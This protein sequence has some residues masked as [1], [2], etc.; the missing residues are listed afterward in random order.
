MKEIDWKHDQISQLDH[1]IRSKSGDYKFTFDFNSKIETLPNTENIAGIVRLRFHIFDLFFTLLVSVNGGL[2]LASDGRHEIISN[3]FRIHHKWFS[4]NC[5]ASDK[6][7]NEY[8]DA[9]VMHFEEQRIPVV[10]YQPEE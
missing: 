10:R 5:F 2:T 9:I 7:L 8:V 1:I 6:E 3:Q 4:I